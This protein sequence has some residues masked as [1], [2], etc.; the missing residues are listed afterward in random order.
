MKHAVNR[1]KADQD[2]ILDYQTLNQA[3]FNITAGCCLAMGLRYAGTCDKRAL[4]CL[5]GVA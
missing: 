1:Q 3:L 4:K 5:V 2:P